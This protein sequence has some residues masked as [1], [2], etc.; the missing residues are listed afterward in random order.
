MMLL[1]CFLVLGFIFLM[2]VISSMSSYAMSCW[3][4]LFWNLLPLCR[5]V[6]HFEFWNK[7]GFVGYWLSDGDFMWYVPWSWW[8]HK[9][10]ELCW[11]F[12]TRI[13]HENKRL[14]HTALICFRPVSLNRFG[15]PGLIGTYTCV[16]VCSNK[17][18]IVGFFKRGNTNIVVK[19]K[20]N[21]ISHGCLEKTVWYYGY[22]QY[23]GARYLGLEM[24]LGSC[25]FY[26]FSIIASRWKV[27]LLVHW[28][29]VRYMDDT[30]LCLLVECIR[31]Q[32]DNW[33]YDL[34]KYWINEKRRLVLLSPPE[35]TVNNSYEVHGILVQ[36]GG[37]FYLLNG[38]WNC[39]V[40]SY[41]HLTNSLEFH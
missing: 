12:G 3:F 5:L 11:S 25:S 34:L 10:L 17:A 28:Q 1:N 39:W 33:T 13:W 22:Y 20:L 14:W 36:K 31:N 24:E 6:F 7:S 40:S 30:L 4:L 15:R 23:T 41:P 16:R 32:N 9:W 18:N 35:C 8:Y 19:I 37:W 29:V 2:A 26:E 21:K 38:A 27:V